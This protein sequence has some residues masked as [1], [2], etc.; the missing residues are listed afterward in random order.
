MSVSNSPCRSL[1]PSSPERRRPVKV[2]NLPRPIRFLAQTVQI[3][4]QYRVPRAAA[5]ISYYLLFSLFPIL[6]IIVG[7]LGLLHLD[8]NSALSVLEETTL[9]ADVLWDYVEYVLTN[10][11]PALMWAGIAMAITASSAAFRGLLCITGEISGRPTFRGVAMVAV[12]FAMSFVLLLVI[13]AFLLAGV[14]GR[15]FLD[16]LSTRLHLTALVR[17]WQW[18]RFPT[19]FA[20]G[21]LAL[22]ALYRVSLSRKAL[23]QSR[24]W[25]GAVVA[26]ISLVIGTALFSMFIS[27]SSRYSLIYGSL[28]SIMI[29]M[30][31][32]FVCSNILVLGN[33]VNYQLARNKSGEEPTVVFPRRGF[34]KK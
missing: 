5:Q 30:L 11:S 24:A 3:Y 27:M 33:V 31:W 8:V 16:L 26:S 9:A 29:L 20:L 19:M 28:A 13:F 15:W 7:I 1:H 32:F 21:V 4:L 17:A 6:M 18:L 25:P 10:E 14:T 2:H 12:S 22:T 34:P 23:P